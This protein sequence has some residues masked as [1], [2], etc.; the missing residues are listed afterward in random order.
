M[1]ILAIVLIDNDLVIDIGSLPRSA[2]PLESLIFLH[3]SE[4]FL[5]TSL[6]LILM[7]K[8]P[9][10]CLFGNRNRSS[11]KHTL[12]QRIAAA[13]RTYAPTLGAFAHLD[14]PASPHRA[15]TGS[16]VCSFIVSKSLQIYLQGHHERARGPVYLSRSSPWHITSCATLRCTPSSID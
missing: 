16:S 14:L 8:Q 1:I 2:C 5:L 4:I 13:L 10:I 3:N 7:P 11:T 9:P 12:K 15:K 6:I